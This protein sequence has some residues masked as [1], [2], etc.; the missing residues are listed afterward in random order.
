[1]KQ[2]NYF[3]KLFNLNLV[4][5][6]LE[7]ISRFTNFE[8]HC[9]TLFKKTCVEVIG[10][11]NGTCD[12]LENICKIVGNFGE[13]WCNTSLSSWNNWVVLQRTDRCQLLVSPV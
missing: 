10:H 4:Q 12:F 8:I 7:K 2:K 9:G 11:C 3:A 1:M 13:H 5:N 6:N